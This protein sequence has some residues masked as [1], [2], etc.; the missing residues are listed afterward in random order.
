MVLSPLAIGLLLVGRF[1]CLLKFPVE[2]FGLLNNPV[3]VP[4]FLLPLINKVTPV[5]NIIRS[6]T[7][8]VRIKWLSVWYNVRFDGL[9]R[10]LIPSNILL[11]FFPK[12]LCYSDTIG[13]F[14]SFLLSFLIHST[15]I[16]DFGLFGL[17]WVRK[18][19]ST[20]SVHGMIRNIGSYIF[21]YSAIR[22][23][24]S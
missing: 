5:G 21:Y 20:I 2:P 18:I 22:P 8:Y 11:K 19:C 12:C 14:H 24:R 13:S 9:S 7:K 10:I 1:C 4:S 6:L 15:R 3:S 16:I 17:L 23:H